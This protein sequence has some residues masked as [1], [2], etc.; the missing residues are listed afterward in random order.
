MQAEEE[1]RKAEAQTG[2]SGPDREPTEPILPDYVSPPRQADSPNIPS[3]RASGSVKA[4]TASD[5][6]APKIAVRAFTRKSARLLEYLSVDAARRRRAAIVLAIAL[7]TIL[8]TGLAVFGRF[9]IW[10]P[11][12]P[13][14]SITI[15]LVEAPTT[16]LFPDLR[17]P[18]TAPEPEPEPI[19][20]PEIVEKPKIEPD[21]TPVPRREPAP[22]EAPK[23]PELEPDAVRPIDLTPTPQFTRPSADETAPFAGE[24]APQLS[25]ELVLPRPGEDAEPPS[26]GV[27][28][29]Q[30]PAEE[31]PPL[32]DVQPRTDPGADA[33]AAE[34]GDGTDDDK[35]NEDGELIAGVGAEQAPPAPA[36][37][38]AFD[39]SPR[40]IK[41][42]APLPS[43]DLPEGRAA[44]APGKSGVVAIFCPEEFQN[45]EKAAECA[46]RTEIRSGWR[47]G[48]SGE[49]WSEA[50]RLLKKEGQGGQAAT[51]PAAIYG[52]QQARALKDAAAA[53]ALS[54]PRRSVG[55][56]NDLPGQSS[57]NLDRTLSRPDI[58]PREIE[59][60][61]TLRDD[62][63]VSRKDVERLRRDLEE[64][65]KRKSPPKSD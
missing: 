14:D 6:F 53:E 43:V 29:L 3:D 27:D 21:P 48:A 31:A 10:I 64:A 58:G 54:D 60:S 8:F 7:N 40:F 65:E 9:Q 37:D 20:E 50:I 52:P 23:P 24:A 39:E 28:A 49:N 55:P 38:D 5:P 30:S 15:T 61:W 11:A 26:P 2:E 44:A 4:P 18:E 41:P 35:K 34:A 63:N 25:E 1:T 32:L 47:P 42:R 57:G 12:A 36:N 62:P 46:G 13:R 51:D 16:P 56:L 59:P 19:I 45:K 33:R 22:R 17:D